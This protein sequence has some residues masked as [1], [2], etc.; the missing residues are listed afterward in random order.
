MHFI[1]KSDVEIRLPDNWQEKVE[2]AWNYV[3]DKVT[4]V[5]IP[6]GVPLALAALPAGRAAAGYHRYFLYLACGRGAVVFA[7]KRRSV[8]A[9]QP[10]RRAG[11]LRR[12]V[13]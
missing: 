13:P 1:D 7:A 5:E 9:L 3:N 4:E 12:A 10:V 11:E 6:S 8:W 2:S